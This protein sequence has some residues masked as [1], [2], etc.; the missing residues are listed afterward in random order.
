VI[1]ESLETRFGTVPEDVSAAIRIVEDIPQL[2]GLQ[3]DAIRASSI[4]TFRP[5]LSIPTVN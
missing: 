3:V 1:L 4:E 2:K 5:R